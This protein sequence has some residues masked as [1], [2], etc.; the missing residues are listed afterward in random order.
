MAQLGVC[1]FPL[2]D[3]LMHLL[4][5]R[6]LCVAWPARAHCQ[7]HGAPLVRRCRSAQVASQA[8]HSAVLSTV[9][10][11]RPPTSQPTTVRA[12]PIALATACSDSPA[13]KTPS[14]AIPNPCPYPIALAAPIACRATTTR[15]P[16]TAPIKPHSA[17]AHRNRFVCLA[18]RA[19]S[20]SQR[21]T[22]GGPDTASHRHH[23]QRGRIV[24]GN[25]PVSVGTPV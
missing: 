9:K 25:G 15:Y 18:A 17:P 11:A 10:P 3:R 1:A 21:G 19:E 22:G 7:V 4:H 24:S 16:R 20:S 5:A 8:L 23:L 12:V 2:P 14:P 13:P 6:R